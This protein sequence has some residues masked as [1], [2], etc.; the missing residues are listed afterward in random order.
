MSSQGK[1]ASERA[2]ARWQ[3]VSRVVSPDAVAIGA[4][5]L[6][7]LSGLNILNAVT[8]S[9][10]S[11]LLILAGY[12]YRLRAID[13]PT[14]RACASAIVRE[15]PMPHTLEQHEAENGPRIAPPPPHSSHPLAQ[16]STAS[17]ITARQDQER[18]ERWTRGRVPAGVR[19]SGSDRAHGTSITPDKT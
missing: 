7:V 19:G 4:V 16:F 9:G 5:A 12:L 8:I 15:H 17:G 3:E 1:P 14:P 11:G 6:V 2:L 13:R 18:S 10:S